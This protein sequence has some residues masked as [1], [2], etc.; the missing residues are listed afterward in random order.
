[1]GSWREVLQALKVPMVILAVGLVGGA[2]GLYFSAQADRVEAA[3]ERAHRLEQ[4]RKALLRSLDAIKREIEEYRSR[5]S[6]ERW[7]PSFRGPLAAKV[8]AIVHLQ[9]L[10]GRFGAEGVKIQEVLPR[11]RGEGPAKEG[12]VLERA[13]VKREVVLRVEAT[14][15]GW[16]DLLKVLSALEEE[17]PLF[18]LGDLHCKKEGRKIGVSF[19]LSFPF[20]RADEG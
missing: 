3:I 14:F 18:T 10:L 13:E 4:Q 5:W 16:G 9:G 11:G 6:L 1:M 7:V 15:K 19:T 17:P 12:G 20:R 8:F 2:V